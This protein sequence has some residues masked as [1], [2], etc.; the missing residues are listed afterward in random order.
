[1][2]LPT[3]LP[4]AFLILVSVTASFSLTIISLDVPETVPRGREVKLTCFYDLEG[5]K[6]YSVKWYRDDVEFFRF[7]PRD[8]PQQLYFPLEGIEVDFAKSNKQTIC[9]QNV[10]AETGGK[11]R[12]EVSADAPFFKTAAAEKWMAVQDTS[13]F[14]QHLI[15]GSLPVVLVAAFSSAFYGDLYWD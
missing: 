6:L 2:D 8:K 7:V 13:G 3:H 15:Q 10:Q 4:I 11:F 5:E 1:M 12:C 9:I 14:P